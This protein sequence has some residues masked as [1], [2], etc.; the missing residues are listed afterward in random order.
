MGYSPRESMQF[1]SEVV[2][3]PN[4]GQ[5]YFGIVA[6][7]NLNNG[8]N[9]FSDGGFVEE[10]KPVYDECNGNMIIIQLYRDGCNFD[11]DTR[12]YVE[13]FMDVPIIKLYNNG[14]LDD[15]KEK[16]FKIKEKFKEFDE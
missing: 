7:E 8:I 9:V 3:K 1:A 5:D 10:L 13:H 16:L 12:Y 14:T 2:I 11:N 4:F 15:F 6:A